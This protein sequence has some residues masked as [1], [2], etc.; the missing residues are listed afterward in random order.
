MIYANRP[1]LCVSLGCCTGAGANNRKP[2]GIIILGGIIASEIIGTLM[3]PS[4]YSLVQILKEKLRGETTKPQ[5]FAF[6]N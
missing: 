4:F 2:F 6:T 5:P 3:A 1:C